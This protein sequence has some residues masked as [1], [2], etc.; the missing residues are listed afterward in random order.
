MPDQQLSEQHVRVQQQLASSCMHWNALPQLCT[1]PGTQP[2][3]DAI[4][5]CNAL[6][7]RSKQC[8]W[9][10]VSPPAGAATLLAQLVLCSDADAQAGQQA[11]HLGIRLAALHCVCALVQIPA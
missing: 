9:C 8:C 11:Q 10:R 2:P 1:Q 3:A 4:S 6:L 7:L 5:C